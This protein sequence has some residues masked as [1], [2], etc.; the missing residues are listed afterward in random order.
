[1]DNLDLGDAKKIYDLIRSALPGKVFIE[2]NF[3]GSSWIKNNNG[4]WQVRS[5]SGQIC[6]IHKDGI[7][8][9]DHTGKNKSFYWLG[10]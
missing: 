1:M 3:D 7:C 10:S 9:V 6:E 2:G 4:R 8:I 5:I